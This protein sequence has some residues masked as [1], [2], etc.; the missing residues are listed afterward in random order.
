MFQFLFVF[1]TEKKNGNFFIVGTGHKVRGH[2]AKLAVKLRFNFLSRQWSGQ[3]RING[4]ARVYSEFSQR[5]LS[6]MLGVFFLL[7]TT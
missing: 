2:D 3:G 5:K 7:G 1:T 4:M 6:N